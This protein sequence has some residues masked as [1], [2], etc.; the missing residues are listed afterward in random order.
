MGSNGGFDFIGTDQ[1]EKK[2]KLED[3]ISYDEMCISALL[4]VSCLISFIN[5][6]SRDN[7]AR[8]GTPGTFEP[9]G[10]IC[11]MVGARFERYCRLWL[12]G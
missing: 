7:R 10:V 8:I 11:G 3:Y 2:L 1:E 5:S 4:G 6:G 12:W 9:E